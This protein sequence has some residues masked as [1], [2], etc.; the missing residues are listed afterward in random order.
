MGINLKKTI[1]TLSVLSSVTFGAEVGFSGYI[2]GGA[3]GTSQKVAPEDDAKPTY[4]TYH[5]IDLTTSLKFSEE[6]SVDLF[7]TMI[8]GGDDRW[9]PM[10]FDGVTVNWTKSFG[11]IYVGDLVYNNNKFG[12]YIHKRTSPVLPETFVRGLGLDAGGATAYIGSLDSDPSVAGSYLSYEVASEAMTFKPYAALQ[13]GGD[14][15]GDVPLTVG[16]DFSMTADQF[17]LVAAAGA[18]IDPDKDPTINILVEPSMDFGAFNV[19]A[20]A[21]Y[22]VQ[23]DSLADR[24]GFDVDGNFTTGVSEEM[25]IYVEPG[26]P[27]NDV[28]SFG[29]PLEYHA[30]DKNAE[31]A[32]VGAY[33]TFYFG[34]AEKA[35]F[36]LWFGADQGI[37]DTNKDDEIAMYFGLELTAEF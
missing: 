4:S 12:Y 13:I 18:I 23:A 11:T 22:S 1:A 30:G 17:G 2:L 35:S 27:I 5:E 32:F 15:L 19:V 37:G 14:K 9:G 10:F 3:I 25:F 6:V 28:V 8:D 16:A 29:I 34:V 36:L 7:T 26:F 33:P 21:Y 24:S 31:S 20:S